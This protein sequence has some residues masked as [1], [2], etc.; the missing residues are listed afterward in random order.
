[1]LAESI[2]LILS[3]AV[4][5]PEFRSLLFR[6]SNKAIEGCAPADGTITDQ[7]IS[8]EIVLAHE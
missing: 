7:G 4:A 2:Q 3:R 6:E 8:S 1:M 5:E